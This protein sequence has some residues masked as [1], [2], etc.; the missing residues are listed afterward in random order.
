MSTHG[1]VDARSSGAMTYYTITGDRE[2]VD[3]AIGRITANYHPLG[4][5]TWFSAL[6]RLEDGSWQSYGSR[7]NSCD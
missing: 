2:F 5:G 1:T 6:K 3:D 7:A 4:Y